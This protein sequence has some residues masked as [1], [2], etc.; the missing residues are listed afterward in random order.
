M[1][2]EVTA[3]SVDTSQEL[4]TSNRVKEELYITSSL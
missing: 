2:E 3:I 1:G 4:N